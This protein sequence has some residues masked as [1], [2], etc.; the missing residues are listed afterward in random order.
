MVISHVP[1]A[2]PEVM[3]SPNAATDNEYVT[4]LCG[5]TGLNMNE[6]ESSWIISIKVANCIVLTKQYLK[7]LT[8]PSGPC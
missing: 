6:F 1:S 2:L 4:T 7:R 5:I 8:E 3:I